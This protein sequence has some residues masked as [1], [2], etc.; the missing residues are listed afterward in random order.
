MHSSGASR[1]PG[2]RGVSACRMPVSRGRARDDI[3]VPG[4]GY[5]AKKEV[6]RGSRPTRLPTL[7]ASAGAD[8]REIR[9]RRRATPTAVE[10]SGEEPTAIEVAVPEVL[11]DPHPLV[12]KTVKAF[13]GGKFCGC[14]H[15]C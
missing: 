8:R 3:P 5:W 13:R 2:R 14:S 10:A 15:R 9:V 6:G 1:C 4:R 11:S 7:P 12:A